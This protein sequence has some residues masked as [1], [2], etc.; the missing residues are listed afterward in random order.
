[1]NH[2]LI[3]KING[4]IYTYFNMGDSVTT[5]PYLDN[6]ID[7]MKY[8]FHNYNLFDYE[9]RGILEDFR[10]FVK[11]KHDYYVSIS[12]DYLDIK[13]DLLISCLV[14]MKIKNVKKSRLLCKLNDSVYKGNFDV[15]SKKS[16][17][18]NLSI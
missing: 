16:I 10:D 8:L 3:V 9:E 17:R 15:V 14:L 7:G 5:S 11:E 2:I 13:K 1:M 18:F 6:R 12:Y 4:T